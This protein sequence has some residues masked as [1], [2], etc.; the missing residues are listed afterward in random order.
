MYL[1]MEKDML[2][3]YETIHLIPA[4]IYESNAWWMRLDSKQLPDKITRQISIVF[5]KYRVVFGFESKR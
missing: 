5:W 4:L 3:G 2:A 1:R